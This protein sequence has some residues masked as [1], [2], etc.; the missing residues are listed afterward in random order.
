MHRVIAIVAILLVVGSNASDSLASELSE[1][2]GGT[3]THESIG[4]MLGG[5]G[6]CVLGIAALARKST[7]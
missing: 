7:K 4:L 1:F 5:A 2:F 3:P 6:L